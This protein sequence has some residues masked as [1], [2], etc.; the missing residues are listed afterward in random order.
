MGVIMNPPLTAGCTALS[1]CAW[2]APE[3]RTSV[4]N[5][6]CG[7]NGIPEGLAGDDGVDARA[8]FAGLPS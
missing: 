3:S 8:T 6:D 2:G 1:V 7:V 4:S 5:R